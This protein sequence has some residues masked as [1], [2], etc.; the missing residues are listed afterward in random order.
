MQKS[1]TP[2]PTPYIVVFCL[3][4]PAVVLRKLFSDT[5]PKDEGQ[6]AIFAEN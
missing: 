6:K 5:Q 3:Q 2:S 1:G 4:K